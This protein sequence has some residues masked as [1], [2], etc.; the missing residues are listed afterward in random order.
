MFERRRTQD[1][2]K[3]L[4]HELDHR[5]KNILAVV[6]SIAQQTFRKATSIEE[7]DAN[8]RGRLMAVA[9]AQD[10]LVSQNVEG[11]TLREIIESALH[12]SGVADTRVTAAG[13]DVTISRR[14]AV[15]MS[16]AI[17]ELCTNALKYGALTADDGSVAITWGEVEVAGARQFEFEWRES[18]GPPVT[19]PH[20]K[21]FGSSLLEQ[22][23]AAELGGKLELRYEP[24][25]VVCHFTAPLSAR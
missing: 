2:Q 22:G 7:A 24:G 16:L 4:L 5:V 6:Q 21:G 10:V 13:P 14:N 18:G 9:H 12:G 23:L 1:Y 3:L 8:F 25:G 17:H 19:T 15:T 20:R 11:A